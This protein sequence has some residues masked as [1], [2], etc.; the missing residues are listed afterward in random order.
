MTV[1]LRSALRP[2]RRVAWWCLTA[3]NEGVWNVDSHFSVRPIV[4][5]HR[6]HVVGILCLLFLWGS[7]FDGLVILRVHNNNTAATSPSMPTTSTSAQFRWQNVTGRSS[8]R[9]CAGT[10]QENDSICKGCNTRNR[11]LSPVIFL[12]YRSKATLYIHFLFQ[13]NTGAISSDA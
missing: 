1:Y 6:H 7:M 4:Q 2:W 12:F 8:V 9:S 10:L 11:W 13:C 5:C 3:G